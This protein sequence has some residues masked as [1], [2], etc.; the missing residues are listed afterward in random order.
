MELKV[1]RARVIGEPFL[2]N[3]RVDI[4]RREGM[5]EKVG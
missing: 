5:D 4:L 3:P 2:I 1:R